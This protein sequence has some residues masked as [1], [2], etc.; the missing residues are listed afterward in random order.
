[1]ANDRFP[2][3]QLSLVRIAAQG[4]GEES[5]QALAT[6]C[7]LYWYPLYAFVRRQGYTPDAAQDLTQAF[8]TRLLEKKYLKDYARDRGRFRSF[9]LAS[10]KHFLSNERDRTNAQKR[11]GGVSA[12]SLDAVI[13]AGERRYS[14]EPRSELTPDRIFE[15]QW[16]LTVLER[17]ISR[18]QSEFD[19]TGKGPQFERMKPF[20]TGDETRIPYAELAGQ[21]DL[22]EG[23]LKV[24]IHRL[25]RRFREVLRDEIAQTVV[26][27]HEIQDEIRYLVSVLM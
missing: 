27:P 10:L 25:R 17:V 20:L 7:R 12:L 9:L 22:T 21:L 3:T 8:F 26:Q 15:R 1:M 2:S 11:G 18:L 19:Q 4:S 13:Q 24:A 16:A 6:L 14:L 5:R 23:A